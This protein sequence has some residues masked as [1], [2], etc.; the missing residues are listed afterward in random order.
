MF[1]KIAVL[2][3]LLFLVFAAVNAY[4]AE[5]AREDNAGTKLWRGV[6]NV[7]TSPLELPKQIYLTSKSTHVFAGVTYGTAKGLCFGVM[8]FASGVYDTVTFP[9]PRY[10]MVL[11]EPKY[12]FDGWE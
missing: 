9:V 2:A 8:R 7:V 4:A 6:V 5:A 3:V 12:V 1:R 10:G 11:L